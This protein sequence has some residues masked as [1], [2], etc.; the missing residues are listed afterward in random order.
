MQMANRL[1]RN[2]PH[3][4]QKLLSKLGKV[5]PLPQ[6]IIQGLQHHRPSQD[7]V[8]GLIGHAKIALVELFVNSIL[9]SLQC[10]SSSQAHI[11]TERNSSYLWYRFF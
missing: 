7:A 9:V 4:T 11:S 10:G 5:I 3:P 8:L 1:L 6:G 2:H